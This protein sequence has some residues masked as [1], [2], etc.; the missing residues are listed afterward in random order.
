M[1]HEEMNMDHLTKFLINSGRLEG[2]YVCSA[3]PVGAWYL[4]NAKWE[5]LDLTVFMLP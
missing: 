2:K 1:I 4:L 5:A 3:E